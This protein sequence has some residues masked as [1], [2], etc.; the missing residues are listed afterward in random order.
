VSRSAP[1][2]DRATAH[3]NWG[4]Q[5]AKL[6]SEMLDQILTTLRDYAEANLPVSRLL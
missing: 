4:L 1:D 5:M 2:E 3:G 6:D